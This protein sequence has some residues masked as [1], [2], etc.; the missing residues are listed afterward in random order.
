MKIAMSS[1]DIAACVEELKIAVGARVDK[2]Y[3]LDGL[4]ILRLRSPGKGRLDLLIE[5]G[6]R[7]HLT[8][9]E[10]KSSRQP[11]SYA[12]FLRKH[13]TNARLA[14][15]NQPKFER[16]LEFRFKGREE[17]VLITELFGSGN[18]ILCDGDLVIIQPYRVEVWRHRALKPGERYLHPPMGLDIREFDQVKLR[19]ALVEAPDIVRGLAVNLNLGGPLAEEVCARARVQKGRKPAE[20]SEPELQ[21]LVDAVV[22]LFDQ[23]LAPHIVYDDGYPIDVLPFDFAS[24]FGKRARRFGSFNQALDEYFSTLAVQSTAARQ[25]DRLELKAGRLRRR[26][27]EQ[28]A[29]L[30]ELE[31]KASD[32]KGQADLIATHHVQVEEALRRLAELRRA[33]GWQVAMNALQR[34]RESGEAWAKLVKAVDVRA[35]V[36]EMELEGKA[37]DVDLRL[38]A[39]GNASK[40]YE[41]YKK[42]AE[43][44]E[45]AKKAV[46]KTELELSELL[47]AGMVEVAAPAPRKRRKPRWFERFRWFISS[48]G[49][50]VIGGRD[51][52]TNREVVEKHMQP[53][54]RYLH[55]D[56]VG[57]PHVVVKADGKEVPETTLREAAELAAMHSRAWREGLGALDV[58]WVLPEQVSRQAPSGEYLPRGSYAVRDKRNF[59][60][61]PVR[62]AIGVV[63]LDDERV[64]MCGPPSA[65]E[66]RS[67][68]VIQIV[69]GRLKKSDLAKKVQARLRVKGV[70]VSIDELMRALPPGRGEIKG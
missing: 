16:I 10:Y 68:V 45:G 25:K 40:L 3:E 63:A 53:G 57:A 42:L 43:K 67:K 51:V 19:D 47:S 35:G 27:A 49:I 65:V 60:K 7:V 6:R 11:T 13:L 1:L 5:P 30:A 64:I 15:I 70:D 61:V 69:P 58:Y 9:M 24:H 34:A 29:R 12:M 66:R 54:D 14:D 38:P 56:I 2:V 55:A 48:D 26:L 21:S 20:L 59:L 50:L 36:V 17:R 46:A 18:L 4:F 23:K 52:A 41:R 28:E 33:E 37:V 62:A 8:T 44:A 39:F 32:A 22:A 31:A